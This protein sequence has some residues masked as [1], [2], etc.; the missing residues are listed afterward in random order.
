MK[1]NTSV[2]LG[3]ER[4]DNCALSQTEPEVNYT[5]ITDISFSI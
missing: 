3:T 5:Y 2:D 4:G 1:H